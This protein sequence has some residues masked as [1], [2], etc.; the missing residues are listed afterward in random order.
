MCTDRRTVDPESDGKLASA[1]YNQ[2]MVML[3]AYLSDKGKGHASFLQPQPLEVLRC[4]RGTHG[5][6]FV[7][8]RKR[9]AHAH[10]RSAATG[11]RPLLRHAHTQGRW[12]AVGLGC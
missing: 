1:S 10:T 9:A 5:W 12:C 3:K 7:L 8:A 4:A 6:C 2:H 11:T